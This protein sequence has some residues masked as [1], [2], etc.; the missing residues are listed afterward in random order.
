MLTE[1]A[2]SWWDRKVAEQRRNH[3]GQVATWEDMKFHLQIIYVPPRYHCDLQKKFRK[4]SQI[5]KTV[6]EFMMSS[7]NLEIDWRLMKPEKP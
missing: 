5:I 4:L 6:E 3:Y 7:N 1:N 2:L